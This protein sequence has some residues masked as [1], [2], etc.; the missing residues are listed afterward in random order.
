MWPLVAQQSF[1][2]NVAQPSFRMQ[3]ACENIICHF[4]AA[5]F[6]KYVSDLCRIFGDNVESS[7]DIPRFYFEYEEYLSNM[8]STYN[9]YRTCRI[10]VEHA[11]KL[12]QICRIFVEKK[13]TIEQHILPMIFDVRNMRH[14][15]RRRCFTFVVFEFKNMQM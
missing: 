4:I 10:F 11:S 3:N 14:E 6:V 7:S 12:C 9:L 8:S 5:F 2:L 15:F 1:R 13:T